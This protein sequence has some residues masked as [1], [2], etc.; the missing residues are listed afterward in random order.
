MGMGRKLALGVVS[1]VPAVAL[2][3]AAWAFFQE[4]GE[5]EVLLY[6]MLGISGVFDL[7]I[8]AW[9][10]PHVHDNRR[11]GEWRVMWIVLLGVPY[12]TIAPIYWAIYVLPEKAGDE[13]S[14]QPRG[15]PGGAWYA[16]PWGQAPYRWWDGERWTDWVTGPPAS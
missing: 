13:R 15:P 8:A 1:L 5:H 11:L 7:G 14:E 10:I 6:L 9:L 4:G 3:V 12:I 2:I 16:D